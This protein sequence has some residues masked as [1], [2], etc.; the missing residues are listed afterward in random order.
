VARL[1]GD[2]FAVLLEE[3]SA[4]TLSEVADRMIAAVA[5]SFSLQGTD[6]VIGMSL[7]I[8]GGELGFNS[9]GATSD[10]GCYDADALLRDADLAM[11]RAKSA[12]KNRAAYFEPAMHTAARQRL[13][14]E[15]ELRRAVNGDASAGHLVLLYQ[16]VVELD[17]GAVHS[18]EALVRWAHPTRGFVPPK[19]F[20][21]IAEESGLVLPLER[22]VLHEA[23][24]QVRAWHDRW[25]ARSADRAAPS[26]TVNISGRH[27]ASPDLVVDVASALR[28]SG[29]RA[30]RLVLELTESMF[31]HNSRVTL[32]R[33]HELKALGVGLAIDDFGTG[34]S[35]LAY[36][37]RFPIDVL[38][39]DKSFVDG[40]GSPVTD[41]SSE[42]P[43]AAA[44]LGIGRA[45]GMLVV[46]EGIEREAQVARLRELGCELGQGY[47]FGRPLPA[48]Q[49]PR[50]AGGELSA[51]SS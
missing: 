25:S 30:E 43:L 26:L 11:Y 24:K 35:S 41:A 4:A 6:V 7:G 22:W 48:D 14:L 23:C 36:L 16:P 27:F 46:A 21:P 29:L 50:Q 51:A 42:S 34:Y 10:Q 31:V 32:A 33:M 44:V 13:E 39:I 17:T 38:K 28:A 37:E 19:D 40:I 18:L 47:H 2:E 15:A 5:A 20:I 8:A 49:V 1:G 12:G 9:D 3:A 45:L